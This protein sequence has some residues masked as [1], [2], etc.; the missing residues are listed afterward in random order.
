MNT[1]WQSPECFQCFTEQ[2]YVVAN[3]AGLRKTRLGTLHRSTGKCDS[4]EASSLY[5][6]ALCSATE[7]LR[8]LI[9]DVRFVCGL[10]SLAL[11]NPWRT[12]PCVL[13][14]VGW[15]LVGCASLPALCL[16]VTPGKRPIKPPLKRCNGGQSGDACLCLSESLSGKRS[17]N[18]CAILEDSWDCRGWF[19]LRMLRACLN[20]ELLISIWIWYFCRAAPH[21]GIS[22]VL[23]R[24]SRSRSR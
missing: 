1:V 16:A 9:V 18:C 17:R 4:I 12:G 24:R 15:W 10:C 23:A 14:N 6:T 2:S 3:K 22:F 5:H 20:M 21:R 13:V 7:V 8:R 19:P 11:W